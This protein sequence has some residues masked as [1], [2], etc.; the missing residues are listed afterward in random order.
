MA[1]NF[2]LFLIMAGIFLA[3]STGIYF[4][5]RADGSDACDAR[6]EAAQAKQTTKVRKIHAKVKRDAPGDADKPAAIE[7]LRTHV[8]P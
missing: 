8:R 2:H 6:H 7:F 3:S 4:K 1:I 5:G